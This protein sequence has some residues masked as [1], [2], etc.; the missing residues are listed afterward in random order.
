MFSKNSNYQIKLPWIFSLIIL[1][2]S[3]IHLS[4]QT[5]LIVGAG[6]NTAI[7]TNQA[8]GDPGPIYRSSNASTFDFS[9]HHHLFTQ[10]E[11]SS[12]PSGALISSLSWF[13]ANN[14]ATVGSGAMKLN[15]Y[16]KNS[17]LSQVTSVPASLATLTNGA[18]LVYSSTAQ[19]INATTGWVNFN[20][21]T[22]FLYS[23]D[24]IEITIDWDISNVSGN[25]TTA[26][27]AWKN[28]AVANRVIS[29]IGSTAST[30]LTNLRTVRA[31]TKFTYAGGNPCSGAPTPGNT[32]SSANSVCS[33]NTITLSLQNLTQGT[34][35][36]YQW[37]KDGLPVNGANAPTLNTVVSATSTYYCEVTCN[38]SAITTASTPVTITLL[39]FNAC[40]CTPSAVNGPFANSGKIMLVDFE[41]IRNKTFASPGPSPYYYIIPPGLGTSAQV[42]KG[43]TYPLTISLSGQTN[44]GVWIDWDH[45]GVFEA[46]EFVLN[47]TYTSNTGTLD[48]SQNITVPATALTGATKMRVRANTSLYEPV[49][50]AIDA[51]ATYTYGE[52]EEYEI[53]VIQATL[54]NGQPSPGNVI[55]N[56]NTACVGDQV[57]LEV[58]NPSLANNLQFQWYENGISIPG[59][60]NYFYHFLFA[61]SANYSCEVTCVTTNQTATT[62]TFQVNANSPSSCYCIPAS[63]FGCSGEDLIA[64][65][66]INT[67]DNNSGTLCP[68]GTIG[69]VDYTTNATL[70]TSLQLGNSYATDVYPGPTFGQG[71]A[72]WIDFND[73]GLFE[74][75]AERIGY[76]IGHVLG[77]GMQTF[78]SSI[79]CSADTGYHR[80]RVRCMYATAGNLITPC[81]PSSFG[82]VE[83]YTIHITPGTCIA[84]GAVTASNITY[85][86]ADIQWANACLPSMYDVHVAPLGSGIPSGNPSHPHV[87][88]NLTVSGLQSSTFYEVYVRTICDSVNNIYSAWSSVYIF[89]TAIGLCSGTPIAGIALS[90]LNDVCSSNGM[91]Q[92]SLMAYSQSPGIEFQ[93]YDTNG[94]IPGADSSSYTVTNATVSNDYYCVLTCT[95]SGLS[96]TSTIEHVTVHTPGMGNNINNP[97]VI[98]EL[99]C[100]DQPFYTEANNKY[101]YCFVNNNTYSPTNQNSPDVYF[102]FQLSQATT[103]HLNTCSGGLMSDTYIH[104]LDGNLVELA[105]NDDNASC[106]YRSKIDT[107]LPA[108]TYYLVVEG[109]NIEQGTF[110]LTAYRD[111]TSTTNTSTVTACDSYTW[112][113]NNQTYTTSGMYSVISNCITEI[114]NLS[115]ETSS[116]NTTSQ[117]ACES[118][119]WLQNNQTYTQSGIY[120]QVNG[121]VTEYLQL[122]LFNLPTVTAP[123]VSA[124]QGAAINL[125]GSP[126]GGSWNL[127][128]PYMGTASSYTYYYTDAN[129]CTGS[130]TA[131]INPSSAVINNL[132]ASSITGISAQVTCNPVG[133]IGWFEYRYK[134]TTSS[135]W[136]TSTGTSPTKLLIGLTPNTVYNLEVRVFCTS[137]T[138][139]AWAST[140]F[141][142]NNLCSTP[143]GLFVNNLTATTAKLNWDAIAG[144]GFYTVQWRKQNATTWNSATT[145][146]NFKNLAGLS[147]GTYEFQVRTHCGNAASVFSASEQFTIGASAKLIESTEKDETT[148]P[149]L[150]PNPA[151]SETTLKLFTETNA[152]YRVQLYDMQGRV[153]KQILGTCEPGINSITMQVDD[154]E[155]GLYMVK[156]MLNEHEHFVTRLRI[157]K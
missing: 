112:P 93:W 65:F 94:I 153:V 14:G 30:T 55:S 41:G 130:A 25:P 52:T 120:S 132:Q 101:N 46:N 33:G 58:A 60:T 13:K 34:Q 149:Q 154:L 133:G 155:E 100:T 59:A 109:Y 9:I 74:H 125:G 83:D 146:S 134:P 73:N 48:I 87:N 69:Y 18:T 3:G 72:V 124:C 144:A 92:L 150:Y 47:G 17:T 123:N 129:G 81:D 103:V 119:T 98:G 127:P 143:T 136:T 43:N 2:L 122:T 88:N 6:S 31:M 156:T 89:Q 64:R 24:G 151:R 115:I 10:S 108:G 152:T 40:Y 35:V 145:T 84:P 116:T 80:M 96:D 4:A 77:G 11:L 22:P 37:F 19:V 113:I 114:L 39:P 107:L 148:E 121:C 70:T 26:G 44:A 139:G 5:D 38:A 138:P 29:S 86:G 15:I 71:F 45:S 111:G 76:T 36:S 23:G 85:Q 126:N 147:S 63:Q 110:G 51:C 137:S 78:A 105:F 157:A 79:P 1:L 28:D 16:M 135:T 21:S 102:Q 97:V 12:M 42:I 95:I 61:E 7:S 118:F 142:T 68:S 99:P 91:F 131:S 75:P 32:V 66:K 140:S 57:L 117:S 56:V 90:N 20:L 141:T 49:I 82:E 27:F 106:G 104:L 128:N 8:G 67:L 54:C 62:P 50:T 53:N